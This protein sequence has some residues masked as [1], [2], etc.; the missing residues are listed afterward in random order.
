VA[1]GPVRDGEGRRFGLDVSSHSDGW[2]SSLDRRHRRRSHSPPLPHR[3]I[4]TRR[5]IFSRRRRR[6]KWLAGTLALALVIAAAAATITVLARRAAARPSC[7]VVVGSERDVLDL[8]QAANA[9]TVAAVAKR[10]GLPDH[11]VTVALAAALQESQLH[12]LRHGDRDSLGMFQ[13]RPSQG[14]GT[15]SQLL[16]PR[17]A[18]NAFFTE[19]ARV[20]NWRIIPVAAAA[21]AV[22]RSSAPEAYATWESEARALAIAMTG[23]R[24]AGLGCRF[25]RASSRAAA[26]ALGPA[27]APELG[28]SSLS[29][30]MTA[31]RGWMVAAWLV[32]HAQ[33]LRITSVS[34]QGR[35]WTSASTTWRTLAGSA[36]SSRV[37]VTQATPS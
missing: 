31:A 12:N 10:R 22:Q 23:E 5:H 14:W 19:L 9:T 27:M 15:P 11:A 20:P 34:F 28:I 29:Q 26:P 1:V 16:T 7:Q 36:T 6:A 25:H 13:Q 2:Q 4:S 3:G 35:Q 24:P 30:P 37:E 33:Q 21:Q 8:E 32:G 17:L 18:A